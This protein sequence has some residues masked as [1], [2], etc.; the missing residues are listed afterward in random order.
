[1][2]F[3]SQVKVRFGDTDPAGVMYFPRFLDVFHQVYED[4]FDDELGIGYRWSIEDAKIGFPTVSAKTDYRAPFRFGEIMEV[5][6]TLTKLGSRSMT[7]TYKAR[8][9]GESD[10]RVY[11]EVVSVVCDMRTFESAEMP[12]PLRAALE[13]RLE[14]V[15]R[16][17]PRVVSK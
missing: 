3:I 9:A 10:V 4:W 15:V 6:L 8:G 13:A 17:V 11:A 7:T 12:A 14:P 2:S 1:M 5:E 16:E